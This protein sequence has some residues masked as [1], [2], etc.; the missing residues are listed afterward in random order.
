MPCQVCCTL[1]A[2]SCFPFFGA[3]LVHTLGAQEAHLAA[4]V[5]Q[6]AVTA[7]GQSCKQQQACASAADLRT[8]MQHNVSCRCC[9]RCV[10]VHRPRSLVVCPG[11]AHAGL[12][13][14]YTLES[15]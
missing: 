10:A 6:G 7:V 1:S 3:G 5:L 15:T 14:M 4:G 2:F 13:C 9:G 8:D 11:C 12:Q